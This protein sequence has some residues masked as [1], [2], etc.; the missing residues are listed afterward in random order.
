M[1]ELSKRI[2]ARSKILQ[3][4]PYLSSSFSDFCFSCL[5]H[6]C[7]SS[8]PED[9]IILNPDKL[10][11]LDF[12]KSGCVFCQECIK[13]CYKSNGEHKGF[14]L[15]IEEVNVRM[16]IDPLKCLA[17]SGSICSSCKDVC[18]REIRF[19]G[20]FYPEVLDCNGCGFCIS[21][22]PMDAIKYNQ[23]ERE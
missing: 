21:R 16:K 11:S 18:P 15:K 9:I 19:V 1:R 5:D 7:L 13:A 14:D 20:M 17:W 3:V 22:C 2:F 23:K 12:S 10:P 8:C 6:P 4:M